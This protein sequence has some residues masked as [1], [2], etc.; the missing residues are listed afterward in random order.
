DNGQHKLW[1][2]FG[3]QAYSGPVDDGVMVVNQ[4][5][6]S[7]EWTRRT[8]DLPA[9]YAQAGLQLPP[10]QHAT[11]RGLEGDLRLIHLR[12]L[13]VSDVPATAYFGEIEQ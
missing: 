10:L 12:L 7:G 9:V 1:L 6:P 4:I 5:I 8:I 11:Y 2:L 13:L 3:P